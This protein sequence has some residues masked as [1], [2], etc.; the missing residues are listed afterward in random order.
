LGVAAHAFKSIALRETASSARKTCSG[1]LCA[2]TACLNMPS[3]NLPRETIFGLNT[4][5]AWKGAKRTTP[6]GKGL[7]ERGA[8]PS[9]THAPKETRGADQLTTRDG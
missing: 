5:P 4:A 6:T 1:R 2:A 8:V 9:S 7:G 3:R